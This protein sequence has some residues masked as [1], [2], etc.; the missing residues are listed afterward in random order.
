MRLFTTLIRGAV[1]E[2]EE[3][4]FDA[5]ATRVLAQQLRDAA[6]SLQNAKTELACAM[7]HRASEAR[8]VSMLNDRVSSLEAGAID[9]LNGGREDLAT[10]AATIIAAAEDERRERH[11]AII[12]L[13]RDIGRLKQL[14][15]DGQRRLRELQRGLEM[16]RAQEALNRAGSNGRRALASG[17]GALREAES[18]L[19]KIREQ[20]AKADDVASALDELERHTT[21]R[22]IDNRLASAGFGPDVKSKPADVLA[23]LS[24]RKNERPKGSTADQSYT[25]QELGQ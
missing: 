11:V 9:A 10:E 18:T 21:G 8:A 13:D 25:G 4:A 23:R 17:M 12:R 3:A 24:A 14:T 19:T 22:D 1:A 5:N 16:A 7:A 20:H 2:A 6:V 15:E